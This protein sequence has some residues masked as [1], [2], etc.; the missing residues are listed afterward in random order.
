M[1][2]WHHRGKK[3]CVKFHF[4]VNHPF[5]THYFNKTGT[6]DKVLKTTTS[7]HRTVAE[8]TSSA[9]RTFWLLIIRFCIWVTYT[10]E[11]VNLYGNDFNPWVERWAVRSK[12]HLVFGFLPQIRSIHCS[13]S[14]AFCLLSTFRINPV[15]NLWIPAFS[16]HFNRCE[17][18]IQFIYR[19]P[20]QK[21]LYILR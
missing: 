11:K 4:G 19:K 6:T 3:K 17:H 12:H 2:K 20:N 15:T 8:F 16:G 9:W 10:S 7:K 5:N 21:A 14:T 18:W 13:D 1:D